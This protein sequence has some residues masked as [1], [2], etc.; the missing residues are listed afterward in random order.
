MWEERRLANPLENCPIPRRKRRRP[1]LEIDLEAALKS[2]PRL[3]ELWD[4]LLDSNMNRV[5]RS[6]PAFR[7]ARLYSRVSVC[8]GHFARQDCEKI[9][10]APTVRPRSR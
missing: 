6:N 1:C 8:A 2:F 4:L 5:A 9:R 10:G 7:A 3:R